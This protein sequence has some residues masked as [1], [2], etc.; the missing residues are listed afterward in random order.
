MDILTKKKLYNIL[1]LNNTDE[2]LS[3]WDLYNMDSICDKV[4]KPAIKYKICRF[5]KK[6]LPINNFCYKNYNEYLSLDCKKCVNER[7]KNKRI[8]KKFKLK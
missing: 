5:C 6:S 4:L 3:N 8:K 1:L 7:Y 2:F